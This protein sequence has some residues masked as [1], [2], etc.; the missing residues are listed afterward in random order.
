MACAFESNDNSMVVVPNGNAERWNSVDLLKEINRIQNMYPQLT[1]QDLS[2]SQELLKDQKLLPGFELV[3]SRDADGRVKDAS[4]RVVILTGSEMTEL[5]GTNEA[6]KKE[7]ADRLMNDS[8]TAFDRFSVG[9]PDAGP[10]DLI[11]LARISKEQIDT[12]LLRAD[13][14]PEEEHGLKVLSLNFATL[15]AD[16]PYYSNESISEKALA[17]LR[18]SDYYRDAPRLGNFSTER[19]EGAFDSVYGYDEREK[20][21]GFRP[22]K[23]AEQ[24]G[25]MSDT[26]K[27]AEPVSDREIYS[28][29]DFEDGRLCKAE[30]DLRNTF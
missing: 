8:H 16:D 7:R 5:I 23:L 1:K 25:K 24:S 19:Y 11:N 10:D 26:K 13:L 29:F 9:N 22:A 2:S 14:T 21:N 12:A 4:G 18:P 20:A 30:E 3:A 27:E 17:S 28:V 15:K 6:A